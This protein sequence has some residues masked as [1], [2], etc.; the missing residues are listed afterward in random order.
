[1]NGLKRTVFHGLVAVEFAG[2]RKE[3]VADQAGRRFLALEPLPQ[4]AEAR[5]MRVTGKNALGIRNVLVS[6][7]KLPFYFVQLAS[8]KARAAQP[9]EGGWARRGGLG[10]GPQGAAPCP[11]R[12]GRQSGVYAL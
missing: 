12:L 3:A 1:M 4:S 2:Q 6:D 7:G 10:R 9:S 11:V 5:E 8:F